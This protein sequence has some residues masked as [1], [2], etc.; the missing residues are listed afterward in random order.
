M[1][2]RN[3]HDNILLR[4]KFKKNA[5]TWNRWA[6]ERTRLYLEELGYESSDIKP[7]PMT[8]DKPASRIIIARNYRGSMRNYRKL[9]PQ[10]DVI[11]DHRHV[12]QILVLEYNS[13]D[14]KYYAHETS[15]HSDSKEV[16]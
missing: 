7:L 12:C 1:S 16:S 2:C 6:Q 8:S 4:K 5:F 15:E 13:P 10:D 3:K 11:R 9:T 14:N